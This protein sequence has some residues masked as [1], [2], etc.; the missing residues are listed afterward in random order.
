MSEDINHDPRRFTCPAGELGTFGTAD[1][2]SN[3]VQPADQPTNQETRAGQQETPVIVQ[4]PSE[5]ELPSLG[6]ATGWLNSPPVKAAELR[7]NVVLIDFCT[8]TCIN[9]LRSLPYVRAWSE[10]YQDKG[11]VVIGVHAPEF[12][13]EH[14]VENVR[15]AVADLRVPYPI[16]LDSD[17]ALWRAFNNHYW[18]ALY[19]VDT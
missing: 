9:W 12:A 6:G 2:Q 8:Y 16:A 15:R 17:F 19:L 3:T 10:K 18:P 14:H 7:G 13:F 11:V 4:L 5:G 1:A